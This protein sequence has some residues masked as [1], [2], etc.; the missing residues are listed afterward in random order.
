MNQ[1]ITSSSFDLYFDRIQ[2]KEKLTPSPEALRLITQHQAF[3]IPFENLDVYLGKE[4]AIEPEAVFRKIVLNRRGG[5]C[6][7]L[8]QLLFQALREVGFDCFLTLARVHYKRPDPGPRTH[9][10]VLVDLDG[11]RWL[12][13]AGFGG[14]GPRHPIPFMYEKV[15]KQF[16]D[17]Y[18]LEEAGSF[19]SVLLK[20]DRTT[21][22][23]IYTFLEE[24]TVAADLHVANFFTSTHPSSIFRQNILCVLP[25]QNGRNIL[26]NDQLQ[27][28]SV[29][30]RKSQEVLQS[31]YSR[32]LNKTFNIQLS[33][34][35]EKALN[36]K[37]LTSLAKT[38]HL[39]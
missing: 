38:K 27:L 19:G 15:H 21:W 6:F 13:D 39:N 11:H 24:H 8:N 16:Q 30:K 2:L 7:E 4:L 10:I 26:F 31:D 37:L 17:H 22:Q 23:P 34:D 36:S 12:V 33:A 25:S 20:K 28:E 29:P 3:H 1:G 35:D 9:L 5:Y 14:P 32:T 18:K